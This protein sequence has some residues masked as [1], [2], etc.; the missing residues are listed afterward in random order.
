[1]PDDQRIDPP[2]TSADR[3]LALGDHHAIGALAFYLG[4][5]LSDQEIHERVSAML[6]PCLRP[7][8]PDP[9]RHDDAAWALA[10]HCAAV[11]MPHEQ[12]LALL[13]HCLAVVPAWPDDLDHLLAIVSN[14]EQEFVR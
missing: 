2:E 14:S 10:R 8:F 5:G 13:A 3:C 6:A 1:M 9:F 7:P 4:A 12:T 11:D